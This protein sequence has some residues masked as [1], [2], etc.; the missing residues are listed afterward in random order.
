MDVVILGLI[1]T[2]LLIFAAVRPYYWIPFAE[3]ENLDKQSGHA[4]IQNTSR[5]TEED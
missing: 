4:N 5:R 2:V 1:T 3:D